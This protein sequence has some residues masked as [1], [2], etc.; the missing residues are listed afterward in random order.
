MGK[1]IMVDGL[2]GSGK[3]VVVDAL[4]EW[5]V[6]RKLNVIDLREYWK[7]KE[8]FPDIINYDVIVSAE[9]TF[10]GWGKKLR[11]ELI[12]KGSKASKEEIAEAYSKDRKDLYKSIIIPALKQ[13][14]FIFQERGIISSLVYQPVHGIPVEDI[15][16]LEGNKFC[17][18][19]PPHLLIITV[20]NPEVVMERLENR[21]KKD[22]S[23]FEKLEFQ[24]KIKSVYESE[25]LKQIFEKIGTKVVYLDT[26][27]P[28]TPE[29][30]KKKAIE[31]LEENI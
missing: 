1:F 16:N 12:K 13:N 25:W 4:K 27:P 31:I 14:K 10:T 19:Y 11:E 24:K 22:N 30:T 6:Q 29:D 8:G 7:S 28:S 3:G 18:E 17:L 5:A 15:L 21:E 23:M 20:V 2:D 9:P 26:N